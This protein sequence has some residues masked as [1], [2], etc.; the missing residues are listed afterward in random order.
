[1]NADN[2]DLEILD[3]NDSAV[4]NKRGWFLVTY[5]QSRKGD[6]SSK[7]YDYALDKASS[8]KRQ[9]GIRTVQKQEHTIFEVWELWR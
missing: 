2:N 9:T 1:M 6:E 4:L 3:G 8:I 5:Y 7:A